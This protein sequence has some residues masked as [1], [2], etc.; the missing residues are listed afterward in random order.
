MHEHHIA[1]GAFD[2]SAYRRTIVLAHDQITLPMPG[3]GPVF[4]LGGPVA[5][6]DHRM[7]ETNPPA[8]GLP[9]RDAPSVSGAQRSG[10]LT[11]QL[12]AAL[13]IQGL[14][15]SFVDH[16][17]L[18]TVGKV[19]AHSLADLFGAPSFVEVTLDESP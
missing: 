8:A 19:R 10:Q 3:Y 18:R 5:D 13:Q 12:A 1:G 14:I 11:A 6:H 17:Q 16:V 4:D 2:K 7:G 9:M 15:D